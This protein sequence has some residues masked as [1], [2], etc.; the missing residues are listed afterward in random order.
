[1]ARQRIEPGPTASEPC[2]PTH[3]C[4]I[5]FV[6][7]PKTFVGEHFGF[8]EKFGYR[9]ILSRSRDGY[10]DSPSENFLSHLPKNFVGD[11]S[12]FEKNSGIE[13]FFAWRDITIFSQGVGV[14]RFSVDYF[15]SHITETFVGEPFSVSLISGMEKFYAQQGYITIF[16]RKI[17]V[18]QYRKIS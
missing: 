10:C 7:V 17:F 2:C 8:S 3:C 6:S 1:M 15:T 13:K 5:F 14:A 11:P 9:K 12:L 16:G 18:S 4:S